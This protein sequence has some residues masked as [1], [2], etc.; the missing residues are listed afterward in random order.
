MGPDG[1]F[2]LTHP[3]PAATPLSQSFLY[4]FEFVILWGLFLIH[5]AKIK[6]VWSTLPMNRLLR[7]TLRVYF[8]KSRKCRAVK[9]PV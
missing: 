8:V 7:F 3:T 9:K 4:L 6:E 5:G 1:T 2:L